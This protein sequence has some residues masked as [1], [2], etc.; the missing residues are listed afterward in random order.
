MSDLQLTD[1]KNADGNTPMPV[2][3]GETAQIAAMHEEATKGLR[4]MMAQQANPA[5]PETVQPSSTPTEQPKEGE[6]KPSEAGNKD[7]VPKQF[8]AKDGSLDQDKILKSTQ[9]QEQLNAKKRELLERYKELQRI[10]SDFDKKIKEV[11]PKEE[12]VQAQPPTDI[13]SAI[14]LTPEERSALEANKSE[15]IVSALLK[16]TAALAKGSTEDIRRKVEMSEAQ[17]REVSMLTRLDELAKDNAW[18]YTDE[19]QGLV[20][21]FLR[22]PRNAGL[23]QT[24]DPYGY[25]VARLAKEIAPKETPSGQARPA[26][27]PMLGTGR[28]IPP[29][30]SEPVTPAQELDKLRQS[31]E[32][33]LG[34]R[35]ELRKVENELRRKASQVF[36]SR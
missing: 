27:T 34:D 26:G 21:Q 25:A 8:Q 20:D 5:K 22:D 16:A 24:D 19:G 9:N 18:L 4:E 13:L 32:S 29:S 14:D 31:V 7:D 15:P 30:T 17:G 6:P 10:G 28:A 2:L 35:A 3:T 11:K 33:N 1:G 12:P 36:S 23:W